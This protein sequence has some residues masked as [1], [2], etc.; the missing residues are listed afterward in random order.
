MQ[1]V[2]SEELP[3][4]RTS[5][6]GLSSNTNARNALRSSTAGAAS[7]SEPPPDLDAESS[8]TALLIKTPPPPTPK[9]GGGGGGPATGLHVPE[10]N[11]AGL[12]TSSS[13]PEINEEPLPEIILAEDPKRP[14]S[15]PV[16]SSPVSNFVE[17]TN[18]LGKRS[19]RTCTI[20]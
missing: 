8:K 13:E 19:S 12:L 11:R 15:A 17:D 10:S 4:P 2:V 3:S 6:W 7:H 5:N 1:I 9:R 20:L 18:D 14:T 16:A